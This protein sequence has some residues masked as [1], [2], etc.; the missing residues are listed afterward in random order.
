MMEAELGLLPP[1]KPVTYPS[2]EVVKKEENKTNVMAASQR[3]PKSSSE[4]N[5]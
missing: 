5:G 4:S 3:V 2:E 1:P